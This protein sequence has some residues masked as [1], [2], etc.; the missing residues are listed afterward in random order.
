V[1]FSA[2]VSEWR[3]YRRVGTAG[4][5]TLIAKGQGDSLP[6]PSAWQDAHVP[7]TPGTTVCYFAQ[8]FDENGNPS[9]LQP[10]ACIVVA[11]PDLAVP[12]V[13]NPTLLENTTDGKGRVRLRWFC[14]PAGVDR[15]QVLAA[16]GTGKTLE[17]LS[18]ELSGPLSEPPIMLADA[19]ENT[20]FHAY[21]TKR[22]SGAMGKGPQFSVT[23]EIP[24]ST[25]VHFSVRAIGVSWNADPVIG[26]A[27]NIV[28]GKWLAP[29]PP[30]PGGVIPWPARPFPDPYE[31]E[32]NVM[33]YA[34]G[35]GPIYATKLRCTSVNDPLEDWQAA[36]GIFVGMFDGEE[37]F[38]EAP[39]SA[40]T[41]YR[42]HGATP[43]RGCGPEDLLFHVSGSGTAATT[44]LIPFMLYRYQLPSERFPN[45]VPNLV[46]CTPLI[47]RMSWNY[48]GLDPVN[49]KERYVVR[50]PFFLFLPGEHLPGGGVP[51]DGTFSR[52]PSVTLGRP[53]NM[54]DSTRPHYADKRNN[55]IFVLD[56]MPVIRS[57]QYQYLV[58]RFDERGEI[59]DVI[60]VNPV[61]Q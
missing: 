41:F 29:E 7:S 31:I 43:E 33:S 4:P 45:A 14:N 34:E 9:E 30:A 10:L 54:P 61:Q 26:G 36:A 48:M 21:P 39:G 15:F 50:D 32:R 24:L 35:E 53:D 59:R 16:S 44:P 28:S 1:A 5:R 22:L 2:D 57:A 51:V 11:S 47:D 40:V 18:D 6:T 42:T 27:G 20:V 46:Q 17:I 23:M 12:L 13:E 3:I 55:Y 49:N 52:N 8:V 37:E 58:V 25:T 60:P 38:H 19:P 56:R